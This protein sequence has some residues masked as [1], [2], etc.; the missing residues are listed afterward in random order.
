MKRIWQLSL[1]FSSYSMEKENPNEVDETTVFFVNNNE[2]KQNIKESEIPF[3]ELTTDEKF[4]RIIPHINNLMD[5][6]YR[7]HCKQIKD[8]EGEVKNLKETIEDLKEDID[9]IK[10]GRIQIQTSKS[11]EIM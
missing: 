11:C 1:F 2:I 7:T 9:L 5:H 6:T 3:N 8:L 4:N 10:L